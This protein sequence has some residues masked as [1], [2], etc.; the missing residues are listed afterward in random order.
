MADILVN[1]NNL[2]RLDGGPKD[3]IWRE[4]GGGGWNERGENRWKSGFAH[5]TCLCQLEFS[6]MSSPVEP[7]FLD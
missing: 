7:E 3:G 1:R 6:R 4:R 5:L 2:S